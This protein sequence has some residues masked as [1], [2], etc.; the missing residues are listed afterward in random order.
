M[1]RAQGQAAA[2][3]EL[4]QT[5]KEMLAKGVWS[6]SRPFCGLIQI[7]ESSMIAYTGGFVRHVNPT[8]LQ[9]DNFSLHLVK[10]LQQ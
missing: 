1:A 6:T 5:G 3:M 7:P 10:K 8:L 9:K 4:L 2:R